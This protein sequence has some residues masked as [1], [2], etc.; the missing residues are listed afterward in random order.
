[1][2]EKDVDFNVASGTLYFAT[3]DE[4]VLEA[5]KANGVKIHEV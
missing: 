4:E 5:I 1:L 3:D 2:I